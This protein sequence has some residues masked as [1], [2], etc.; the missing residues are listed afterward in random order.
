M[1]RPSARIDWS[2][3]QTTPERPPVPW[4]RYGFSAACFTVAVVLLATIDYSDRGRYFDPVRTYASNVLP[5][6]EGEHDLA[7]LKILTR[8]LGYVRS[9]YVDPARTNA[10]EMLLAALD[11]VERTVPEL[12]AVPEK[13]SSGQLVGVEVRVGKLSKSFDLRKVTDL[14]KLS[15]KL[16]DIFNFVTPAL[17]G[18]SVDSRTI[19]YAAV[20]GM[21]HTLDPHS[22]LLT[23]SVYREM[24]TGTSGQFGG[25]GIVL[26]T[27]EGKLMV[28]SVMEGSPAQRAGIAS[29]DIIAQIEA[30]S[31]VNMSLSDAVERLR[32]TPGTAVVIWIDR[33][34]FTEP[35]RF[36]I[37]RENITL[38]S[39]TSERL[40]GG[41]GYARIK[42]FQQSSGED[43]KAALERLYAQQRAD[44]GSGLRGF[45]LDLRDNPGGLLDQAIEV[46]DLF[47]SD[48]VIVTT[49]GSGSRVREERVATRGGT[50]ADLPLIVLVNGGSASASEIVA[51]ALKNQNRALILG[52]RTFGKGSVQVL[53][54][55]DNIALK[56]TIA[57][58]LTPGDE[59]IQ[60]V[61]I[62]P[63]IELVPLAATKEWIHLS[64]D[65][66]HGEATLANHLDGGAQRR[67]SKSD[68]RVHYL[69]DSD[70]D[71]D[72][73]RELARRLLVDRHERAPSTGD[74][75]GSSRSALAHARPTL[76]AVE[77]EQMA[78]LEKALGA[79]NVDWSPRT[80]PESGEPKLEATLTISRGQEMAGGD[81][82]T[83]ELVVKNVGTAPVYQL[84]GVTESGADAFAGIEM[85][86]GRIPPGE[87]RRWQ[88]RAS[89]PKSVLTQ[90]VPVSVR[91]WTGEAPFGRVDAEGRPPVVAETWVHVRGLPRPRFEYA[92][93]VDDAGGNGD[94]IL[95]EGE[96]VD[97]VVTVRNVGDGTAEK[98]LVTLKN[99]GSEETYIHQGRTFI[100]GLGV[101]KDQTVR[102]RVEAKEGHPAA[103]PELDIQ[104]TDTVLEERLTHA[105]DLPYLPE[106]GTAFVA[107]PARY[108]SATDE[109]PVR[110]GASPSA[111]VV[112]MVPPRRAFESDG[113]AGEFARVNLPDGARGFIRRDRLHAPPPDLAVNALAVDHVSAVA[114]PRIEL[115]EGLA[116]DTVGTSIVLEGRA[117]FPNIDRG[118]SPDVYVFRDQD[119]VFFDR[120]AIEGRDVMTFRAEV[121]LARGLNELVVYARAGRDLHAKHRLLVYRR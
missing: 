3:S 94:G 64:G 13:D 111:R 24:K 108:A 62:A 70:D 68:V 83:V 56:L 60:G 118:D 7:R 61:G 32:G 12:L 6:A 120:Q 95:N 92:A 40:P 71:V 65:E 113:H 34:A 52:E 115:G 106:S 80:K 105:L 21:L 55:I 38:A 85:P 36:R 86:L 87:T 11:N 29:G 37:V 2:P 63:N 42:N 14:Y 66:P 81:E 100:P 84:F 101:G 117:L 20:N 16:L 107:S 49:V 73:G 27:R 93:F 50:Y 15:W 76:S 121:P 43:L 46:S 72:F 102:F 19:E 33:R 53:Y 58:Y 59:S 99:R 5:G 96:T 23:P 44:D 112:A 31:T 54:D 18:T 17:D 25:L 109:V 67:V 30:E 77:Q 98:T 22:L 35:R 90:H 28:E 8:C 48:G 89:L 45:V 79:L 69:Y 4:V 116:L 9:N 110:A 78:R 119:K 88:A 41:I 91:F 39:V 51:G 103:G 74:E 10:A 104:I 82:P 57:Q 75:A 97:V 26:G 114:Q 47:V 1:R